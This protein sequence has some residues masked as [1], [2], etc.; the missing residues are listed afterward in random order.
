MFRQKIYPLESLI[1]NKRM[2]ILFIGSG[3]SSRYRGLCTWNSLLETIA[4]IIGID[5]F[6]LNGMT[7]KLENSYPGSNI[8]PKLASELSDLMMDGIK[9]KTITRDTFS[10]M[11]E[12][13]WDKMNTLDP[14]KVM[15]C[16]LLK[17]GKIVD[18]PKLI[19]EIESFKKLA[20]KIPA[21]ITTNYD[22][23]L[24]KEIFQ[25]FS[26][27]V[28]PDDYYFSGSDGYGEILKIHGTVEKPDSLIVTE[29]DY[30]RLRKDSKVI[31][32]RLISLMCDHPVVFLGYSLTDE[33]I[34]DI[35]Y[36]LVS[37]LKQT[38]IDRIRGNLINVQ[39]NN[40]LK[41]TICRPNRIE[42]NGKY[43]EIMQLYVPNFEIVFRYLDKITPV[44][45]AIEIK[46]Y[47]SM[48]RNIVLSTNPS[49]K[50][51]TIINENNLDLDSNNLAVIFGSAD[52]LN[53][54][55][56]GITGYEIVDSVLDVLMN[57]SSILESSET[58]F[59]TWISQERICG[60]HKY[61]PVF[62]YMLKFGIDHN[63]LPENVKNFIDDMIRRMYLK[64]KEIEE[65]CPKDMCAEN[66]DE[67][68]KS[69]TVSFPRC[70]AL[71]Y[72]QHIGIIDREQCRVKLQ[73]IYDME[74]D[75]YGGSTKIK[76]DLR[77]A[78]SHL[79]VQKYLEEMRAE[80]RTLYP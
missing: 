7:K 43:I 13:E 54:L 75:E 56:K 55:M 66:I 38:D 77:C 62:Y 3:V 4:S 42:Q 53:S 27:L 35:I 49:A 1:K 29:S 14:F 52:S 37:S 19:S 41:K 67:F 46:R 40:N 23:F 48:I 51:L 80:P 58:A 64:I 44:A 47:R 50:K 2:P 21:V 45:T 71:M 22:N 5:R 79:D 11:T 72:F 16:S 60:G 24:E 32:S 70:D 63:S 68:L 69:Q 34:H 28:F 61:I 74:K 18:D 76:T 57:R 59:T 30:N 33:E 36:D 78:I 31:M 9:N 8:Y 12:L 6:Q 39:V 10:N 17:D 65:K 15:V 25:N 26:V 20:D 73:A